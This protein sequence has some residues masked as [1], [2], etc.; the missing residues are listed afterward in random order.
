MMTLVKIIPKKSFGAFQAPLFLSPSGEISPKKKK[1]LEEIYYN[2]LDLL[3]RHWSLL[4]THYYVEV[5]CFSIDSNFEHL[6]KLEQ[7][8][9]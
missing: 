2:L 3:S 7:V 4:G 1:T 9:H 8:Y 6:G 5:T